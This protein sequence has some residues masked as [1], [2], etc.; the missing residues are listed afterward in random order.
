M[1]LVDG[2]VLVDVLRDDPEWDEWSIGQLRAH[3]QIHRPATNPVIR[4]SG[5]PSTAAGCPPACPSTQPVP[6]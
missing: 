4:F 1:L 2:N 3:S 5:G 6:A